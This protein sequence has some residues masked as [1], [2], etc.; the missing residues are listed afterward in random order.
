MNQPLRIGA[1]G[2]S[3][4]AEVA[5]LKPARRLPDIEIAAVAARDPLRA[6]HFARRYGIARVYATYSALL[7][8]PLLD[9]IYIPLPNS[10]HAPWTIRALQAGKHVLCEKPMALNSDEAAQMAHVADEQG[11][12]LIEAFHYRYHPLASRLKALVDGGELGQVRH[13]EVEFSVPLF[14][15]RSIQFRHDLGGGAMMDV[16]CYA[17]NLLRF[18]ADAEPEVIRAKA[19]LIRTQ[20]DRLM[21]AEFRF[22]DG[23]SAR[24]VCSL[25]SARLF[26]A[27]AVVQGTAGKLHVS[28]P[29]LPHR[30]HR[31]TVSQGEMT[32]HEQLEGQSTYYYQLRAFA[33]AIRNGTPVLTSAHDAIANMRVI[34]AVYRAAGLQPRGELR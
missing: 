20:V 27:T 14:Q 4:M 12:V 8:D 28:L 22:G 10:L 17:T 34:D 13:I 3:H 7:D 30:F 16:G 6:A 24:I 5:L 21:E 23:R 1:L 25:L 11:R 29:F 31:I 18:L 19:R 2:A 26:R 32:R 15:P 9:A 33:D